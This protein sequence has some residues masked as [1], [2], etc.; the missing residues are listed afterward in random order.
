VKQVQIK[1]PNFK[2]YKK[3]GYFEGV[4]DYLVEHKYEALYLSE[5]DY[6]NLVKLA[7]R[8]VREKLPYLSSFS[9]NMVLEEYMNA[10]APTVRIMVTLKRGTSIAA[11]RSKGRRDKVQKA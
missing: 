1:T 4:A 3:V 10:V 6:E 7:R 5:E 9:L 11:S 2:E 8:Q